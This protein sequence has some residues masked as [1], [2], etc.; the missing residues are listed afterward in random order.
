MAMS[1]TTASLVTH[2]LTRHIA[3]RTLWSA[4]ELR[5][6]PGQLIAFTGES[7]CGKTTLLNTL[8]L[9]ERPS[10]GDILYDGQS[11]VN[12][13]SRT[14]RL[15]HRNVMGFMFQN[16]A[17]VEQWTVYKNLSLALRSVGT[18]ARNRA[19]TIRKALRKVHM[20]QYANRL[21]YTLSGGEQQRV[22]IARLLIRSPRII[23]ADEPTAALDADNRSMVMGH[24]R[25]FAD[26]GAIVIYT[27]HN[28]EDSD[29]ADE[30][31]TL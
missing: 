6:G 27:T 1:S 19:A 2:N 14:V 28:E 5:F 12:A 13:S 4:L 22:A 26:E 7:G 8:G 25:S 10:E 11:L 18:P 23:L 17:L 3:N 30:I 20:E 29:I 24:L 31:I 21:V 9:L 16:Y 15:M